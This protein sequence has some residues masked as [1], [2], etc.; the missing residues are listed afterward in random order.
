MWQIRPED[1]PL[2]VW[3]MDDFS[4]EEAKSGPSAWQPST[5]RSSPDRSIAACSRLGEGECYESKPLN[6]AIALKDRENRQDSAR[7]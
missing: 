4:L 1:W 6:A 7:A 2:V 5:F 3:E